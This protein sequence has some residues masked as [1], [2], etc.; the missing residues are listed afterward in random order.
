MQTARA[1]QGIGELTADIGDF[2]YGQKG[3]HGQ[4]RQ[5]R[6]RGTLE[7]TGGNQH[8][9]GD[10]HSEAAKA[11]R[12]FHQ[13]RL[14]GEIAEKRQAQRMVAAHQ[15]D[16]LLAALCF[17]AKGENFRQAL[18]GIDRMGIEFALRLAGARRQRIDPLSHKKRRKRDQR[19]KRRQ[20]QRHR[21]TIE[22]H[23][24]QHRRRHQ[25]CD[26]GRCHRVGEEIFH[27]LDILRR[28]GNQVA[29]SSAQQICRRER[30]QFGKQRDAH[31]GEQAEGHVMRNPG[32]EPMQNTGKGGEG[33][34]R[35]QQA[36]EGLAVAHRRDDEGAQHTD[37]DQSNHARHAEHKGQPDAA[38]QR[39][40][41]AQQNR[42]R[43]PPAHMPSTED[44]IRRLQFSC[45]AILK[46]RRRGVALSI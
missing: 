16:E 34:K 35:D 13:R 22:Q 25:Q 40:D 37:A 26:K 44:L 9:S 6:Q 12:R 27:V 14:D 18:Q 29:A 28:H 23:G 31:F 24:S 43:P 41:L 11:G 10:H 45:L 7:I 30:V 46:R 4:Q 1:A 39:P 20:R 42:R 15:V 33:V 36:V 17:L 2:R 3:G 19:Q 32:F 8:R 38:A 21:P 5:Q